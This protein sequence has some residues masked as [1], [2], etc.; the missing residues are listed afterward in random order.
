MKQNEYTMFKISKPWG[1]Y[2]PDVEK[3]I[4]NYEDVIGQLNSKLEEKVQQCT[5]LQDR[6]N[7]LENELREMHIEMSSMELPDTEE[8]VESVVLQDFRNYPN[9]YV[10]RHAS[11]PPP[12]DEGVV[13]IQNDGEVR[14]EAKGI[15]DGMYEDDE[16]DKQMLTGQ[17]PNMS[18]RMKKEQE[19]AVIDIQNLLYVSGNES[20]NDGEELQ[21]ENDFT[22]LT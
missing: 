3:S 17:I 14:D 6:I 7:K 18:Q 20:G 1:Y 12:D 16:E 13:T 15:L 2:P 10:E 21:N 19:D 4:N 8:L 5:R 9:G 11:T 22:I